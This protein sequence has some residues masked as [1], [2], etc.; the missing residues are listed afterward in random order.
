MHNPDADPLNMRPEDF[1]CDFCRRAWAEDL[2]MVEGHQGSLICGKCLSV[3]YSEVGRTEDAGS[4][5]E[6]GK[7]VMCLEEKEGP[8]WRSVMDEGKAICRR[9]VRQSAGMLEKDGETGWERP[10]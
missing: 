9:C 6:G 3:A 8:L 7:C 1:W 4:S 10:R 5:G 2:P